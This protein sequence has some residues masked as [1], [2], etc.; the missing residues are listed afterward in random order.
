M[1]LVTRIRKITAEEQARLDQLRSQ[2]EGRYL[3]A[4]NA[5][6]AQTQSDETLRQVIR[7]LEGND[8]PGVMRVIDNHVA[9]LANTLPDRF[10][11]VAVNET[12]ELI[13]RVVQV[14]PDTM[15]AGIGFNPTSERAAQL[16]QENRLEFVQNYGQQQRD[17]TR[18][19]LVDALR[20]G[21]GPR[22][23]AREFR[24]SMGLTPR[25]LRSVDNYRAL[26]TQL[27][28][29]ALSRDLRDRRYDRTV[30]R[31]IDQQKPLTQ[32][33]IDRMVER[34][35]KR[36]EIWRSEMVAR[37]ETSKT[38]A[39]AR[40]EAMRQA[41]LQA[42]IP[43]NW[44][45]RKWVTSMDGRER[46][47]HHAMNGQEVIGMDS[48]F[49]SPSGARLQYPG[50][51]RAPAAEIINCRCDYTINYVTPAPPERRVPTVP[52]P[53]PTVP[54]T[55]PIAQT[56][57]DLPPNSP[58]RGMENQVLRMFNAFADVPGAKLS[59]R[60][61]T[62]DPNTVQA[63]LIAPNDLFVNRYFERSGRHGPMFVKHDHMEL[64]HAMQGKGVAKTFMRDS[65]ELYEQLGV[66]EVTMFANIDV[67]GYAWSKY[68][69]VPRSNW[70]SVQ[71]N[72][73]ALLRDL[74][75]R[76][77]PVSAAARARIVQVVSD[78]DP[79]GIWALADLSEIVRY[80][81]L[82]KR[83]L[84]NTSWGGRLRLDDAA[85]MKRFHDYVN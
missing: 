3:R 49:L 27:S 44:V 23:A 59:V 67:G 15:A 45:R 64:P 71:R 28:R 61:S 2:T 70:D 77:I 36:M 51:P 65:M 60:P 48:F 41:H 68:G 37:T 55:F 35:R 72:A 80:R 52:A 74:D 25:M 39:L 85:A 54:G 62:I 7:L 11:E 76:G 34:Y 8:L 9:V 1:N 24:D 14:L 47:T 16:M 29:E 83:L 50:D 22:T 66:Q 53:P 26:L 32:E 56:T 84:M 33:Q 21:A 81:P 79:Q 46:P 75:R 12:Q 69:F 38:L 42:G 73:V 40:A 20:S 58:L 43:D 82:G 19:A 4:L 18:E 63:L 78:P 17:A 31:A 57:F 13:D 6:L 10:R 30:G 5:F